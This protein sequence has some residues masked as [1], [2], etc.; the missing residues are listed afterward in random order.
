MYSRELSAG[1]YAE[2]DLILE[3]RA[4]KMQLEN[5]EFWA[6]VDVTYVEREKASIQSAITRNKAALLYNDKRN[7]KDSPEMTNIKNSLLEL[8]GLLRGRYDRDNLP[9]IL[10][11]YEKTDEYMQ[12][13]IDNK[14]PFFADG[15]RRKNRVI[16]L[17]AEL[18]E[19]KKR[20]VKLE[21]A[22]NKEEGGIESFLDLLEG[23]SISADMDPV[24][25]EI[26]SQK[27]KLMSIKRE[28]SKEDEQEMLDIKN[29]YRELGNLLRGVLAGDD[30][31]YNQQLDTVR[32]RYQALIDSCNTFLT[33]NRGKTE[34]DRM[35]AFEI[36]KL[37]KTFELEAELIGPLS[38]SLKDQR[39][40]GRD[41][42]WLDAWYE[43]RQQAD[44]IE[45]TKPAFAEYMKGK[46]DALS[47]LSFF[48]ALNNMERTGV[49]KHNIFLQHIIFPWAEENLG[50]ELLDNCIA[51]SHDLNLQIVKVFN[52]QFQQ[53]VP[54]K[55]LKNPDD[56]PYD[57]DLRKAYTNLVLRAHPLY[58]LHDAF[59]AFIGPMTVNYL[60]YYRN[61]K[62]GKE[63]QDIGDYRVLVK[64]RLMEDYDEDTRLWDE[65]GSE[66]FAG[67]SDLM[68]KEKLNTEEVNKL[69]G[70]I[71]E[72]AFEESKKTAALFV[73]KEY[74]DYSSQKEQELKESVSAQIP[75]F[76][77]KFERLFD[78]S[79]APAI[80]KSVRSLGFDDFVRII[81]SSDAGAVVFENGEFKTVSD[82]TLTRENRELRTAFM[83]ACLKKLSFAAD[84]V[85]QKKL[86]KTLSLN[87]GSVL[88]TP[89]PVKT[90]REI[91]SE[92]HEEQSEVARV[93]EENKDVENLKSDESGIVKQRLRLA[94]AA[95]DCIGL[96]FDFFALMSPSE[97][98]KKA[99]ADEINKILTDAQ[100]IG[101]ENT[102]L[103]PEQIGMLVRGN[104]SRIK[105]EIFTALTGICALAGNLEK[106]KLP[107]HGKLIHDNKL[108]TRVSALKLSKVEN[109]PQDF[110]PIAVLQ[111]ERE[112][113][114]ERRRERVA[115]K[116]ETFDKEG[117]GAALKDMNRLG[118]DMSSIVKV[119]LAEKFPSELIKNDKESSSVENLLSILKG[120]KQG[121]IQ[122]KDF[123]IR[124]NQKGR[125]VQ[126]ENGSLEFISKGVHIPIPF[127]AQVIADRIETDMAANVSKYGSKRLRQ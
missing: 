118:A 45:K 10:S 24:Q 18:K 116:K 89:L 47:F 126:R 26:Y 25:E 124:G 32:E 46:T 8:D 54:A 35:R 37:R 58:S 23:R 64:D 19:E 81:G 34:N 100:S 93:I 33:G 78:K 92:I 90:I 127:T 76:D 121:E 53:P 62:A 65:D 91:I 38:L 9:Q 42:T 61:L 57:A 31:T 102:P 14:N 125:L 123:T 94:L 79:E 27:R 105:D 48:V 29:A 110:D 84:A 60:S 4:L 74:F 49:E 12:Y 67:I 87:N 20:L 107:D 85:E 88:S 22:Y 98:T 96:R 82:D 2:N 109:L 70:E 103:S 72:L 106:D 113:S 83:E 95:N 41:V 97:S 55:F 15:K 69:A 63:I 115:K 75:K 50:N 13:Y 59:N 16:D 114:E 71:D 17:Q 6:E 1:A 11:A 56:D 101:M 117:I 44:A 40:A 99:L 5:A 112:Q 80:K 73:S 120:F 7:S 66:I 21:K 68:G 122:V 51:L 77:L 39:N 36:S 52:E 43:V 119:L 86:E 108:M 104:V 28:N 3:N 30:N 111:K